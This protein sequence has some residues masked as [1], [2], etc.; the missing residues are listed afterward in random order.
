[1]RSTRSRWR[2]ETKAVATSL[3][4]VRVKTA[5]MGGRAIKSKLEYEDVRRIAAE[6][7]LPPLEVYAILAR[8]VGLGGELA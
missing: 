8:E 3:G 6:R 2:R 5:L 1:M 7:G 4:E